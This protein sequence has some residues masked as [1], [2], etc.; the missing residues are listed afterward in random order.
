MRHVRDIRAMQQVVMFTITSLSQWNRDKP[1]FIFLLATSSDHICHTFDIKSSKEFASR[2]LNVWCMTD[3]MSLG[4]YFFF[5]YLLWSFSLETHLVL[6]PVSPIR[7]LCCSVCQRAAHC[8]DPNPCLHPPCTRGV[9]APRVAPPTASHPTATASPATPT[10]SWAPRRPA[11]TWTRS[12]TGSPHRS[13]LNVLRRVVVCAHARRT[14]VF[15]AFPA[16]LL[17]LPPPAV[18]NM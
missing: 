5:K 12:G 13:V 17:H 14:H 11:T 16:P 3:S 6:D 8:T 18:Q 2:T 10:P 1:S 4:F 7:C 15:S 9:W